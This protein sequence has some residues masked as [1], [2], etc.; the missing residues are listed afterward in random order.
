[1]PTMKHWYPEYGHPKGL[2]AT[3]WF[4][5]QGNEVYPAYG[6]PDGQSA[7]PWYRIH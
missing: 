1:M 6:H 2:S 7:T 4:S 3:P 5:I